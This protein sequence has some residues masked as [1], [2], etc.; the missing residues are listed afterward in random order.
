MKE[1]LEK[2]GFKLYSACSCG[3]TFRQTYK[4]NGSEFEVT[5]RP[6]Q[7]KFEIRKEFK[8]IASGKSDIF[9]Q[10]F[11]RLVLGQNV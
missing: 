7:G 9:E 4:K 6:N 3:G 2:N 1:I 10:E 11:N 5:I 8:I